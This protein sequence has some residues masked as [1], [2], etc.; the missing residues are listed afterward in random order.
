MRVTTSFW[1]GAFVRRC[2]TEGAAALVVRHGSDEAGAILVVVDRLDGTGDIY[3]P[4]PQSLMAESEN[5]DRRFQ[6]LLEK[7]PAEAISARLEQERKFDPDVWIIA[8]EDVRGRSFL[9]LA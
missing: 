6:R 9:D 5:D 7:V 3:G 2:Y 8:V 4:A 1:V